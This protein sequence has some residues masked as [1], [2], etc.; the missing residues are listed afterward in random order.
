MTDTPFH[1]FGIR[2][3]GPG[4][5]RSLIQALEHLQPDCLLIEGP[6][7]GEAVLP[8]MADAD[9]EPPVALL[10]YNPDDSRQAAFYP[11]A[12]F[13]PEW[14][15]LHYGLAH[16][17]PTRFID[18]PMAHQFAL[19]PSEPEVIA[20]DEIKA[21][22]NSAGAVNQ[23]ETG[24]EPSE[25]PETD[26]RLDPLDWLGRAAGYGDGESLSLIHI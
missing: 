13:S 9:L 21:D 10:V 19:A 7:E 26:P 6:L 22:D 16:G 25:T 23:A 3:H 11:F 24:V 18:L 1:L 14:N 8:L 12:V 2:H 17:I 20:A 5:A 4:C 15:A